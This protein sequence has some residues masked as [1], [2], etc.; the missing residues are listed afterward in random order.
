MKKL[1]FLSIVLTF[2]LLAKSQAPLA[3]GESAVVY[4]LPKMVF[5]IEVETEKTTQKPGQFYRYSERYLGTNKVITEEKT[6][7]QLK[8]I[9][10]KTV[11]IPDPT[12]TY[13][14]VPSALLQTSHLSI[15]SKGILCGINVSCDAEKPSMPS[16][17]ISKPTVKT[18]TILPLGEEYMMAGSEAKLAEGVAK[19][20]YRIRESRL[21]LLTADVEKMPADGDSFKTMLNG[22]DKQEKELT[23]LFVGKS[24]VET[25]TQTISITPAKTLKEQV[26]FRL[27]ALK[28]IVEADDLSGAPYYIN[29]IPENTT[30]TATDTKGKSEKA[31]LY[32]VVPAF[33]LLTIG[34]V[35]NTLYSNNYFVPQFGK[36]VSIPESFFKQTH[37]KVKIDPQNGRLLSIE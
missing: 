31:G 26:L 19:Q 25:Q 24:T 14:L 12:R 27:S 34:D 13:S 9:T 2:S 20:I 29:L 21:G 15:N 30:V 11:S 22:L 10:V 8:N 28:G 37:V 7:F 33:T 36:T 17:Q 16:I 18:N 5:L 3:D 1:L 4:S 35:T 32:S 6:S 23:E